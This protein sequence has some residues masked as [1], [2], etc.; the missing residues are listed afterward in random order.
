MFKKSWWHIFFVII[1]LTHAVEA[2]ATTLLDATTVGIGPYYMDI[3]DETYILTEDLETFGSGLVFAAQN[4]TLDLNNHTLTFGNSSDR[5]RFGVAV[6][7]AYPHFRWVELTDITIYNASNGATIKNG[8]IVQGMGKAANCAAIKSLEQHDITVENVSITIYGDDTFAIHYTDCRELSVTDCDITDS[9]SVI[10]NRHSGR[11]AIDFENAHDGLIE[12]ARNTIYSATQWGIRVSRRQPH[13][14][15]GHIFDNTINLANIVTNGYGLGLH[16]DNLEAYG[17]AIYATNGRG[18]HIEGSDSVLVHDNVVDVINEPFWD[19]YTRMQAHG[20]KLEACSNTEVYFNYVI[21]Y[22][23]YE[24]IDAACNGAALSITVYDE[25]NNHIHDNTFIAR[26]L[27]GSLFV[28]SNYLTYSTSIEV[29]YIEPNSNLLI[30]N[31]TFITQDR[32]LSA[33]LDWTNNPNIDPIDA[34]DTI[35]KN[36][37][38]I[39]DTTPVPTHKFDIF[40][41][42]NVTGLRF[43][44][45]LGEADFRNFGRGWPWSDNEWGQNWS[46][47]V[48]A[49]DSTGVAIPDITIEIRNNQNVLVFT[50][51]SDSNGEYIVTLDEFTGLSNNGITE[52]G[53]YEFK[54]LFPDGNIMSQ[55]IIDAEFIVSL[56]SGITVGVIDDLT[57]PVR[58]LLYPNPARNLI[59][60]KTNEETLDLFD[61]TGRLVHSIKLNNNVVKLNGVENGIWFT[62][63]GKLV[64]IN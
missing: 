13:T 49:I 35:I 37:T 62:K 58:V 55:I 19:E 64:K 27:G 41:S 23:R 43:L 10:T 3:Q 26:H 54:A 44:N 34:S 31:N 6:P 51:I 36:N 21:S 4:V 50:G 8:S 14:V 2:S 40:W 48:R 25:S 39:R 56:Q 7:P 24:I 1:C 63:Y 9:T 15:R 22:G 30:E 57:P 60:I 18:I 28:P 33:S 29:I 16:G 42:S 61:I 20:I 59:H 5:S 45:S 52:L 12:I 38:W 17:N 32:F 11:A 53:P 46:G 47:I